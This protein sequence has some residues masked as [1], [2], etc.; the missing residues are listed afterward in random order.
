MYDKTLFCDFDGTFINTNIENYFLNFLLCH[1]KLKYYQ[2]ILAVFT[3]PINKLRM[4]MNEP[5]L[6]KAWSAFMP[7]QICTKLINEFI[8]YKAKDI[9]PRKAVLMFVKNFEG[10]KILLTGSNT[11]LVKKYLVYQHLDGL[12]DLIIGSQTEKN[13]FYVKEHP[14]GKS[15]LKYITEGYCVG[16]GNEFADRFFLYKCNKAYV[17][18]PD[19]RLLNLAI[20][21]NWTILDK[22]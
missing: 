16:I 19:K 1:K 12:F 10:R 8:D 18:E 22:D 15:K 14:F 5:N 9:K 6:F 20:Q 7:E 21:N 4:R 13:G 11:E 17:I 3:F 2:Y